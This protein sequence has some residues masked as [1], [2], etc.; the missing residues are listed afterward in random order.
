M[1]PRWWPPGRRRSRV[2]N[3]GGRQLDQAVSTA[4]AL[5]EV[6]EAVAG[7]RAEVYV[8][9]GLRKAEHVL[10]ALALGARAVFLGRPLAWS[11]VSKH[12]PDHGGGAA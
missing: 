5:P 2:S 11:L 9:G 8:D 6:A 3:H 7:S 10:A 4:V 12:G 1:R